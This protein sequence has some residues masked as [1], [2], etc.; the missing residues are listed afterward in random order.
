MQNIKYNTFNE[1]NNNDTIS[2]SDLDDTISIMSSYS[3][4]SIISLSSETS[5]ESSSEIVSRMQT[6]NKH[7]KYINI[8]KKMISEQYSNLGHVDII[9]WTNYYY[10]YNISNNSICGNYYDCCCYTCWD[11]WCCCNYNP[12][13]Y[14]DYDKMGYGRCC[15]LDVYDYHN[16]NIGCI[17]YFL[18]YLLVCPPLCLFDIIYKKI[19]GYSKTG[20]FECMGDLLMNLCICQCWNKCCYININNDEIEHIYLE[21]FEKYK[22]VLDIRLF[23]NSIKINHSYITIKS[24]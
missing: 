14:Y 19:Y 9:I 12:N 18:P 20:I 15:G 11:C 7:Q 13:Y 8:I 17:T 1:K 2:N 16:Y 5:S 24:L 4:L 21:L 23:K 6:D 3:P 10:H 22:N